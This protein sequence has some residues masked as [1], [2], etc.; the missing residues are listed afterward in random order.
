MKKRY[1]YFEPLPPLKF[2]KN[3]FR[4]KECPCG[5][6][7]KDGKFS[8]YV[9]YDDKGYCHSCSKTFLP[10]L[11]K[12]ED[13]LNYSKPASTIK[14]KI[15][16]TM[17]NYPTKPIINT[18]SPVHT[19]I[20]KNSMLQSLQRGM[21]NYLTDFLLNRFDKDIVQT[22]MGE[23]YIGS[24]S[25]WW[26]RATMFWLIDL[27]GRIRSG[28]IMLYDG[29]TGKR[30]QA[31]KNCITW[32]HI[33]LKLENFKLDGCLFG[34]HLLR[35]YP[36]KI[37][38]IVESEKT[39][40]IASIYFPEFI[41]LSTGGISNLSIE[42]CKVL[43]GRTVILYP[44]LNAY[45]NWVKIAK[46]LSIHIKDSNFRISSLL[47]ERAT[48]E[49]RKGKL[50]LADYLLRF[51]Y[52]SFSNQ[53]KKDITIVEEKTSNNAIISSSDI[54]NEQCITANENILHPINKPLAVVHI[55]N[56]EIALPCPI[57]TKLTKEFDYFEIVTLQL[58]D[59]R[60]L[61]CL[62]NDCGS[63]VTPGTYKDVVERIELFFNKKFIPAM[64]DE[65]YCLINWVK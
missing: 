64:V 1:R 29:T 27:K 11:P 25:S 12:Q 23:Y 37:V 33:V 53:Q 7:N 58:K 56:D 10:E 41:W 55:T 51:D 6:N 31:P 35:K 62:F 45:D 40:L 8:P 4:V 43:G 63:S 59:G 2:D 19:D 20:F 46:E 60:Y 28:K 44:D 48:E 17:N 5:R 47:E 3:R 32:E 26:P 24:S 18:S 39:A 22:A 13:N 61:D 52:K 9:G 38:A 42:K 21:D 34:E 30:V 14:S 16:S 50:D 36:H 65:Y 57:N 49:E 15:K 54:F